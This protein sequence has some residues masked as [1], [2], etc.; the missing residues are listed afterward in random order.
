MSRARQATT[1]EP[2][3]LAKGERDDSDR[4]IANVANVL[5]ALRENPVIATSF[6]LD[7]MRRASMVLKPIPGRG[8]RSKD[9]RPEAMPRPVT[10]TDVTLLQEYLQTLGLP[11]I[12]VA[13][14]HQAVDRR[15][16][17]CA[18]HPLADY[19]T[20]LAWDGQKRIDAW[21]SRYLGA[22]PSPYVDAIGEMFLVAM[23]ARVLRPGCKVDYMLVLEGEQGEGKSQACAILAGEYFSDS[24][25]DLFHAKDAS[26][27]L[28][29]RWLIEVGELKA[30]KGV[31]K[32]TLKA[33][34][35]RTEERYRPP[36]GRKEVFEPRQCIFVGTTNPSE[37]YL[38]DETGNRRFWPVK[39]GAID[40]EALAGDRDQLLAEAVH[41]Y[42]AGMQWWPDREFE[43]NFIKP[44]QEA[45]R[46][47]DAWAEP[48]GAFL[49]TKTT[50]TIG[51]VAREAV[52]IG[53]KNVQPRDSKRIADIMTSLEWRK[54]EKVRDG[55]Y[56]WFKVLDLKAN[57]PHLY[58]AGG[59]DTTDAAA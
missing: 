36:H 27:H 37:G 55:S 53:T 39:T 21:L 10:D 9:N 48:I 42:H 40:L 35:T 46:I 31:D 41:A 13:T 11:R 20:G 51:N 4:L 44:Q 25:P 1:P 5:L 19:L 45:R 22:D 34:L 54:S 33:F 8:G 16:V 15:A 52:G 2:K 57:Q 43:R 23:V 32:E 6:A 28:R 30:I 58:I 24:L 12:G 26:Q 3:W 56:Y 18:Y 29:G 7:E 59:T 14:I 47:V 17:E 50:V 49:A 38:E